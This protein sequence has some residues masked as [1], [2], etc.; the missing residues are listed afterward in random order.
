MNF[1]YYSK[2]TIF[3]IK[4]NADNAKSIKRNGIIVRHS[5]L[6]LIPSDLPCFHPNKPGGA[7]PFD[8]YQNS[9][10]YIGSPVSVVGISQDKNWYLV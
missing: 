8:D 5:D 3:D 6:R 2:D 1:Q 7:Y 4:L 9:R 10:L